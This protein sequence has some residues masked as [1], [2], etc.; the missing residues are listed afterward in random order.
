MELE[1]LNGKGGGSYQRLKKRASIE[2]CLETGKF[3]V[4][5]ALLVL[6]IL[7]NHKTYSVLQCVSDQMNSLTL[8]PGVGEECVDKRGDAVRMR[9]CQNNASSSS[10]YI[11]AWHTRLSLTLHSPKLETVSAWLHKCANGHCPKQ[12]SQN[13]DQASQADFNGTRVEVCFSNDGYL[14]S[15]SING[16]HFSTN[17]TRLLV[18]FLR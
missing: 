15:A 10:L 7:V 4:G 9:L 8:I 17:D 13:C 14:I 11:Y 12:D 2:L 1:N 16:F 18:A 5:A 6:L 3:G